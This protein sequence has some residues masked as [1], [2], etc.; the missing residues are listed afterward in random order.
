VNDELQQLSVE[1]AV[2]QEKIARAARSDMVVEPQWVLDARDIHAKLHR[3]WQ[4]KS[5]DPQHDGYRRAK[6]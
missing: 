6:P 1:L 5:A 4:R 3:I 2:L